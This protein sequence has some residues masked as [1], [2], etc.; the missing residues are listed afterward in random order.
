M[1]THHIHAAISC[2]FWTHLKHALRSKET[3]VVFHEKVH[4]P[5]YQWRNV[6]FDKRERLSNWRVVSHHNIGK[7]WRRELVPSIP[8]R[9]MTA[10]F[11]TQ[12]APS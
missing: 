11:S 8:P 7:K 12:T 6:A 9:R 2:Q 1:L 3:D 10:F 4:L 5:E